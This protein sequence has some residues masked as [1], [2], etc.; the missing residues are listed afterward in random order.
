VI[1]TVFVSSH[2]SLSCCC[3]R[4]FSYITMLHLYESLGWWRAGEGGSMLCVCLGCMSVGG[5]ARVSD[6]RHRML[7]HAVEH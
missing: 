2:L 4:Y 6:H 7:Q 3:A 1:V 5:G